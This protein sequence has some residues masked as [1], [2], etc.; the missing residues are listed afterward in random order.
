MIVLNV[1][2]DGFY[3]LAD[4]ERPI[5]KNCPMELEIGC[6]R[7]DF[8]STY[9]GQRPDVLFVGVERHLPSIRKAVKKVFVNNHNTNVM[10][11]HADIRYLFEQNYFNPDSFSAIHLY[12]PDPWPKKRH[13]KRR[14][15]NPKSLR[16]VRSLL[17]KNG[18]LHL[19]SDNIELFDEMTM[20]IRNDV[21]FRVINVPES[22][23]ESK[24]SFEK[25]FLEQ[26][27]KINR[28]SYILI[29]KT[30]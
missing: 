17:I 1:K 25:R 6:G 24:T 27:E 30:R 9:A 19:R 15:L 18:Y 20:I 28:A 23:L 13:H 14:F 10:L 12:F 26:G 11:I 16:T 5:S 8:L 21:N 22:L 7:G 29:D 2:P 3:T 4:L